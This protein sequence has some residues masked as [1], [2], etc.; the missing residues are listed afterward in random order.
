MQELGAEGT[1]NLEK[2]LKTLFTS[3]SGQKRTQSK[4]L[5]NLEVMKYFQRAEKKAGL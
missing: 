5:W 2:K 1:E 4:S 3:R